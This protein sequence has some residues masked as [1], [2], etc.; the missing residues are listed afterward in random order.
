[1]T[2]IGWFLVGTA[3]GF[4]IATASTWALFG[5]QMWLDNR[6]WYRRWRGG[7]WERW[8]IDMPVGADVWIH[9]NFVRYGSRPGLGRGTPTVEDW[10]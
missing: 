4:I 2:E 8:W 5:S 9:D 7:H 3:T 10:R 6:Q 1:M